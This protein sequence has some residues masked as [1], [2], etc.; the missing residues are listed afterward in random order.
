MS[1][2]LNLY[3][4]QQVDT[5][6]AQANDRLRAIRQTL[7][8]DAELQQA[9]ARLEEAE[10]AYRSADRDMGRLN[11]EVA[12]Q[13]EKIRRSEASLYGGTIKNPKELQDLQNEVASLKR[14]LETL[15]DRL[16]HAM[17]ACEEAEQRRQQA[18]D[19]LDQVTARL[20]EQNRELSEEAS[21]LQKDLE[22]L[23]AERAVIAKNLEADVLELYEDLRRQRRGVAVALVSDGA[24][25]ACGTTLTPA[26]QQNA[27]SPSQITHCPTCGR[28][29]YSD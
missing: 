22:R 16:L 26:E 9:R 27:R 23:Q 21:S 2:T 17:I 24:C 10:A 29:L 5:R 14:H 4:L 3:R 15:E 19:A 7:E 28:I 25:A 13:K 12:S 18:Q 8:N 11:D 6:I 20:A 1:V